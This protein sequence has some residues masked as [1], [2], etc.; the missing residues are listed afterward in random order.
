[1][2]QILDHSQAHK[3]VTIQIGVLHKILSVSF[4]WTTI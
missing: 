4:Y 3:K 2:Q 1:M